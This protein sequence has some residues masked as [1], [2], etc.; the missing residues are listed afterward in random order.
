MVEVFTDTDG[1]VV[2]RD[3]DT[4][5]TFGCYFCDVNDLTARELLESQGFATDFDTILIG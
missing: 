1:S 4:G 3:V 5:A 2:F